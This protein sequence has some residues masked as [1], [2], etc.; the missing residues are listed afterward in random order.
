MAPIKRYADLRIWF[1]HLIKS[2]LHAGT[3]AL[4]AGVGTNAA[5]S[6]G[7]AALAELGLSIEQM[8]AV[9]LSAAFLEALRKVHVATADIRP[10]MDAR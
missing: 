6:V 3:G 5:A 10:P 4:L 1:R 8:A 9:F 7:P 2:S